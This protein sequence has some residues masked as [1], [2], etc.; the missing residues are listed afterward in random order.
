MRY[1]LFLYKGCLCNDHLQE[2]LSKNI[3][4]PLCGTVLFRIVQ[5][6][7]YKA[8]LQTVMLS[9]R[10]RL[11]FSSPFPPQ[12]QMRAFFRKR[13]SL[14]NVIQCLLLVFSDFK[15]ILCLE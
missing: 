1:I 9:G 4:K 15:P 10:M 7:L 8:S 2:K 3:N 12:A 11:V 13:K 5:E 14:P 6:R